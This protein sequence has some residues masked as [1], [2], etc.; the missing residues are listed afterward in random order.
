LSV[1]NF[2]QK[3]DPIFLKVL[4]EMFLWTRKKWLNLEGHA[5]LFPDREILRILNAAR[6]F[7][8]FGLKKLTESS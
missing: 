7:P 8:Q 4:P 3:H 5:H 1:S 6:H 2:T